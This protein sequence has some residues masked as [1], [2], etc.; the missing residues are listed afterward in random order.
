MA[1]VF[2]EGNRGK[3]G[4]GRGRAGQGWAGQG[5]APLLP[6]RWAKAEVLFGADG[7]TAYRLTD[8]NRTDTGT[9]WR[10]MLQKG[11]EE[12]R[13]QEGLGRNGQGAGRVGVWSVVPSACGL[14]LRTVPWAQLEAAGGPG[15][16]PQYMS[17]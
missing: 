12:Q 10:E 3:A 8:M 7:E 2:E 5:Q 11:T 14:V 6:G 15:L 13:E 9:G 16:R 4:P 17:L 1:H